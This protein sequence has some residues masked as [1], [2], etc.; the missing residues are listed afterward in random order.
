MAEYN[1][2]Y[3]VV[4]KPGQDRPLTKKEEKEWLKCAVDPLYFFTTYCKVVGP[5]GK[6]LFEPRDYQIEML[7][8]VI[9]HRHVIFN[10]PRQVGKSILMALFALHSATF[11]PDITVGITSYRNSGCKD[12]MSRV[13]SSYEDLPDFLKEP[14]L[15]YNQSEV[16][17]ANGSTIFAQVTS[18]QTFRGRTI[19]GA[20]IIDEFAFC[21]PA[22]AEDFYTSFMPSMEA[23]GEASKVKVIIIS[24]P[25]SSTGKYAEIA[26]GAMENR[27]GFHYHQVDH[28]KIP[29]RTKEWVASMI[30][31]M[32]I[33]AYR[34]EFEGAWL[35]DNSSLINSS[36]LEAIKPREPVR[37]VGDL[38]IFVDSF[39][40]RNLAIACDVSEGVGKDDH[41]VQIVDINTFEQCAEFANNVL[42]QTQY[43]IQ[44]VKILRF[45]Y[46]EG[47]NEIYMSVEA[48]GLGNGVLRLIENSNEDV[49]QRVMFINDVN[50][51]GV[52]TGRSG[53]LTTN[54][55]KMEWASQFKDMVEE[56]K[57]KLY[58]IKLLNQ[59]RM[60]TKQGNTF[61]A[62]KGA[63]DDRCM[64]MLLLMGILKQVAN[65]E[66]S[67]YDA[68]NEVSLSGGDDGEWAD[69]FF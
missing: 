19:T 43:F 27:N 30:K 37:T 64:A 25:N 36:I 9:N 61:K 16:R 34:Q 40:N 69:I 15:L 11:T 49:L 57:M 54:K 59:L 22:I 13:K 24:T 17:F 45:L 67:V 1:V 10:A 4:K 62:E 38:E 14:V 32:G 18:D 46:S 52:A 23:A 31:K 47:T 56:G 50:A 21:S 48:N 39:M 42:N 28:T 20:A 53:L 66:D 68:I 60:F 51:M 44:L 29:G 26:F 7:N 2:N 5:T 55:S 33:N 35:S 63:K 41:C 65:Y 8:D 58:S 3:S 6:I 12:L